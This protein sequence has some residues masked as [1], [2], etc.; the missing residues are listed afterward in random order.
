M[1]TSVTTSAEWSALPV[2][3]SKTSWHLKHPPVE[4]KGEEE[5]K[6]RTEQGERTDGNN[7]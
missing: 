5:G 1:M 3:V 4:E 6:R 2:V 7:L